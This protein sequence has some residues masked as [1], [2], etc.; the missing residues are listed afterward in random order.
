M[1]Q[2]PQR[3]HKTSQEVPKR[4]PND[5][6][7]AQEYRTAFQK[8]TRG[9]KHGP[10]A[11]PS[12]PRPFQEVPKTAQA[13]WKILPICKFVMFPCCLRPAAR[14]RSEPVDVIPARRPQRWSHRFCPK[15]AHRPPPT[16]SC[17]CKATASFEGSLHA[18]RSTAT[19]Q[20]QLSRDEETEQDRDIGT[21]IETKKQMRRCFRTF[22]LLKP[23]LDILP[24]A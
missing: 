2:D 24:H 10:R 7:G 19:T 5:P 4:S 15:S 12:I 21:L 17:A 22:R 8:N 23:L 1:L 9:C 20:T 3:Q 16:A 18:S 13:L 14:C 11:S 6:G